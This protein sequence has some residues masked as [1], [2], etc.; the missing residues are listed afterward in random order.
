[1]ENSFSEFNWREQNKYKY[2]ILDDI[3]F[4]KNIRNLN[5]YKNCYLCIYTVNNENKC[6]FL[7]FLFYRNL[8]TN[9]F[10]FLNY[11]NF[12]FNNNEDLIEK[13]N[14]YILSFLNI[15]NVYSKLVNDTNNSEFMHSTDIIF[16]G[17]IEEENNNYLFFDIPKLNECFFSG[18]LQLGL[19]DEI[20]NHQKL[21]G[22]I[23][24]LEIVDFFHKNSEFMYL[25]N[26]KDENYEIPI[27]AYVSKPK[28]QVEF[29]IM[30]GEM[31]EEDGILGNYY[32]FT[33]YETAK[34]NAEEMI[35]NK[36][37]GGMIKFAL[38]PGIM[39]TF[40]LKTF[41]NTNFLK[42]IGKE[43]KKEW[44]EVYDSFFYLEK[45]EDPVWVMKDYLQQVP[46]SIVK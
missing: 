23:I 37:Y 17:F 32:Y 33:N 11:I 4:Y 26:E 18:N 31:T 28:K 24:D 3:Y 35:L 44:I 14:E 16:K 1:M 27:V 45:N 29:T 7:Q 15:K 41:M 5:V 21:N 22:K 13:I 2:S 34:K 10:S 19:I 9:T 40:L 12:D 8:L 20:M 39:K 43:E 6:P 38:F 25:K 36:E 46:L 42:E 30:F